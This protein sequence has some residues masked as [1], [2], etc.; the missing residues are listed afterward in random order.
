MFLSYLKNLLFSKSIE[1]QL[2][3]ACEAIPGLRKLGT[4]ETLE[5][6]Y[7]RIQEL[8]NALR[9]QLHRRGIVMLPNDLECEVTYWDS[10]DG[11][12]HPQRMADARV[13]TEFTFS[14]GR[15]NL[16]LTAFG[17][18]SDPNGYAV[19]IAQTMGLKSLLKRLS[20]IYGEEDDPE[21][22]RWAQRPSENS[23]QTKRVRQYQERALDSALRNSGRTRQQ[24]EALISEGIGKSVTVADIAAFPRETFDIA[25][26]IITQNSDL[27]EVL[28]K[29]IAKAKGPQ[30]VVAAMDKMRDEIAGD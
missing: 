4:N 7:L 27:E 16:K 20:L 26:K 2:V 22:P 5:F 18:A 15:R 23:R 17:A 12:G 1:A 19:A 11:E 14:Q 28:T 3:E 30:P 21:V 25:M 13:K 8:A 10:V 24:V 6:D 29:S 9:E